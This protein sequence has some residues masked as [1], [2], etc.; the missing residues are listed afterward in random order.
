MLSDDAAVANGFSFQTAAL[1][2]TDSRTVMLPHSH[3]AGEP[4]SHA[5]TQSYSHA[6]IQ[7]YSHSLLCSFFH[8]TVFHSNL[9]W[10][11][12]LQTEGYRRLSVILIFRLPLCITI[13]YTNIPITD[14][15]GRKYADRGITLPQLLTGAFKW[16]RVTVHRSVCCRHN[17]VITCYPDKYKKRLFTDCRRCG[18]ESL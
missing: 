11:G 4:H 7:P 10:T 17:H 16:A 3:T 12:D 5:A 8:I 9:R 13:L 18:K 2:D 14:S 1:R 6:A 15:S